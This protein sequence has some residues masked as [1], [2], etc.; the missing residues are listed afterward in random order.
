MDIRKILNNTTFPV[1]D[2]LHYESVLDFYDTFKEK[3]K[4]QDREKIK[5][6]LQMVDYYYLK[7]LFLIIKEDYQLFGSK[8]R[9]LSKITLRSYIN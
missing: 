9:L 6:Y 7:K 1:V 3:L 4:M 8:L 5:I 2:R